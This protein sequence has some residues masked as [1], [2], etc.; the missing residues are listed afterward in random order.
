MKL[1]IVIPLFNEEAVIETTHGRITEIL[2]GLLEKGDVGDCEIVYVDDGSRD[3][4]LKILRKLAKESERVKVVSFSRNFGHQPALAAGILHSTGDAV[5]SL[6][7]D[8]QDPPEL[9]REMIE[10]Y[11]QGNDIVYAVRSARQKDT[12]SKADD[13]E[14][15]L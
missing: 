15:F 7:A 12:F 2:K 3:G 4:S 8:L 5:V 1:S 11:R 14:G 13:C 6:D 10:K 9:I